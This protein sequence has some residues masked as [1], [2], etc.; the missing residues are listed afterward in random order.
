MVILHIAAIENNPY[1]GVCVAA[2]MHVLSQSTYAEVGFINIK[3]IDIEVL[4]N[5]RSI[6]IS[7][8]QP[9]D[10]NALP[11][12]YDR[13]DIVVFHECYRV[14]YLKIARN[15]RKNHIPYII[16]P[17]GE[18]REE[19]QRK[20]HL[21]KVVANI[22][23]FNDFINHALAIQC[24]SSAEMHATH[25]GMEKFIG[26]NGIS[27]PEKKKSDFSTGKVKFLY[28][29]RYEWRVKGLDILFEAI[30]QEIDFIRQNGCTFELY[31]PDILGRLKQVTELVKRYEIEDVVE[32][33]LEITGDVKERAILDA[34][35]FIQTS[36]HEGMPMGILEALSYGV[37]CL[38]SEGTTLAEEIERVGAGWNAG[39][40]A[41]SVALAI[42]K[43]VIERDE[44]FEKGVAGREFV[45]NS[46]SW[47]IVSRETVEH[48]K[49][50]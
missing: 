49:D 4:K 37:P 13:P 26:T 24:L 45:K 40:T 48:Y 28:I 29:G 11:K 22:L 25:H 47:D 2:P 46:Y 41:Q 27:V 38:I 17:H 44:W 1:N 8:M 6:Q 36:R 21:K 9:F 19:A 16:M 12:P 14:D 18:L 23:L 39:A 31:G 33:N 35:I 15:L 5:S 32:L 10:I 43:A 50:F 34:D 20:K 30:H 3:N 7:Y 42:R